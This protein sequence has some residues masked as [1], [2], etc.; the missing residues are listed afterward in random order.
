[1]KIEGLVA[2]ETAVGSPDRAKYDILEML[3]GDFWSIQA[4]IVV[5]DSRCD[6]G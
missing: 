1:M 2:D 5:G 3:L 6:L 4:A